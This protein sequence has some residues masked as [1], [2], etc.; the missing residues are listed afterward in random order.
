MTQPAS[1]RSALT[2]IIIS[3]AFG[4][5]W[6]LWGA[7]GLSGGASVAVRIVGVILGVIL[8]SRSARL[9]RSTPAATRSVFATPSYRRVVAVEVIA[10]VAG[11][12]TLGATG[13]KNYISPWVAAVVGV[14]FLPFGRL[15]SPIYY[16]LAAMV[17]LAALAGTVVGLAGGGLHAIE[18]TT[19]LIAA[20]SML[21]A[22][23]TR[24]VKIGTA[25]SKAHD[26]Q[27]PGPASG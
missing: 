14:H 16:P 24:L 17:I 4:L 26:L 25:A 7:S 9:R 21:A 1:V 2:G 19:G 5:A 15:F 6:A 18:A 3:G 27:T 8:I 20:A 22:G 23:G 12:V 13:N 11:T 10:L